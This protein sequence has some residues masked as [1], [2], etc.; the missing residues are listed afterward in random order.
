MSNPASV[1]FKCVDGEVR[2]WPECS[3]GAA[4]DG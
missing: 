3:D 2:S 4:Q 1:W